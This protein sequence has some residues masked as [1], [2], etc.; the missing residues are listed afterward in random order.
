MQCPPMRQTARGGRRCNS[1]RMA[2]HWHCEVRGHWRQ[3]KQWT[4]ERPAAGQCNVTSLLVHELFGGELL[5]TPYL[6]ATTF[7][8]ALTA[9]ATTSQTASSISQSPTM[10]YR[11]RGLMQNVVQRRRNSRHC[12]RRSNGT[13]GIPV[14]V[15]GDKARREQIESEFIQ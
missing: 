13:G 11:L 10:T 4:R 1:N 9:T 3:Q 12:E 7:T 8:I 15:K 6:R 5:K 14:R 2:W